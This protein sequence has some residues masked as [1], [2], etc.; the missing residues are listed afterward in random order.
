MCSTDIIIIYFFPVKSDTKE[1]DST[2]FIRCKYAVGDVF[3]DI[4]KVYMLNS[5]IPVETL[6]Q[7]IKLDKN[8]MS[9]LSSKEKTIVEKLSSDSFKGF[10][11]SL[12]YKIAR[13]PYFAMIIPDKPTHNWGS[14]PQRNENTVGDNIERIRR[15]K[16]ELQCNLK[17]AMTET[18]YREFFSS[19]LDVSRRADSHLQNH[20]KKFEYRIEH[21][22][23]C[24]LDNSLKQEEQLDDIEEFLSKIYNII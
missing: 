9:K 24:V 19:L 2:R 11:I 6:H 4:M 17:E 16:L 3:T 7:C 21:Y 14:I 23:K 13:H 1:T 22:S 8:F 12:M 10:S 20:L 18:D 5:N 15:C